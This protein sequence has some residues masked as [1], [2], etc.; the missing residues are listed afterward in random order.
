[1]TL[2]IVG[3]L[4]LNGNWRGAS[5]EADKLDWTLQLARDED[6]DDDQLLG[7][8]NFDKFRGSRDGNGPL[9]RTIRATPG[10]DID[11]TSEPFQKIEAIIALI[12]AG[13]RCPPQTGSL[14]A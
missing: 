13:V 6:R 5:G 8:S 11:L 7:K 4:G 1:M 14:A 2:I 10:I 12:A 3:H 9:G